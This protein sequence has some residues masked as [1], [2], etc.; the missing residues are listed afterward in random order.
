MIKKFFRYIMKLLGIRSKSPDLPN[1]DNEEINE[2]IMSNVL[3]ITSERIYNCDTYCIS[4][5]YIDDEYFC[6]VLEDTDRGLTQDMTLAE[7]AKV[8]VHGETAIPK[9]TYEIVMNVVSPKYST[10]AAYQ[11]C[12]GK[13]PRLVN[14]PGYE[15]ILI[16]IGNYP[17]DTEGCL[18]VGKNTVKGAVMESTATFNTLYP[19]LKDAAKAGKKIEI[20]I[21]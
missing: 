8:K 5:F 7:I 18:L 21:K 1:I 20:T 4:K 6:D 16:H 12:E 2:E 14:V 17:K 19:I 9:G 15:G 10:R 13:L 11:F 3:K